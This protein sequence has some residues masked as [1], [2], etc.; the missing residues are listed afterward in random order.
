M[1]ASTKRF[2]RQRA[3]NRC[4]YCGLAKA[5]NIAGQDPE[6]GSTASRH[7]AAD[8]FVNCIQFI[9][10][11]KRNLFRLHLS[12]DQEV[13]ALCNRNVGAYQQLRQESFARRFRPKKRAGF[14][15]GMKERRRQLLAQ[16]VR[17][18]SGC[19]SSTGT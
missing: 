18:L 9:G 5:S 6:I 3:S 12:G 15:R 1:D 19:L 8:E 10:H 16:I 2:V 14:Q 17:C 13:V 11:L 7:F 4:E